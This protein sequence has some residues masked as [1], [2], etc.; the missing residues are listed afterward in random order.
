MK[1]KFM[2]K[3]CILLTLCMFSFSFA[4]EKLSFEK[5]KIYEDLTVTGTFVTSKINKSIQGIEYETFLTKDSQGKIARLDIAILRNESTMS[6]DEFIS[7]LKMKVATMLDPIK[8]PYTDEGREIIFKIVEK[9]YERYVNTHTSMHLCIAFEGKA[10]MLCVANGANIGR[11]GNINEAV[12]RLEV[13][14]C[15][16]FILP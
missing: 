1:E 13:D 9:C 11:Y 4:I 14:K 5:I 15:T 16:F 6:T 7:D 10:S 3:V 12:N 2:T 8:A